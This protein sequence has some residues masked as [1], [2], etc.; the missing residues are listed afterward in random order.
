MVE[1]TLTPG[2]SWRKV[3]I[4]MPTSTACPDCGIE[5]REFGEDVSEM[6]EFGP[7]S[8]KVIRHVPPKLSCRSC[9]K[10]SKLQ[11]PRPWA[12]GG[13][14]YRARFYGY[15]S[16]WTAPNDDCLLN[17]RFA[18]QIKAKVSQSK[19]L[20]GNAEYFTQ[21]EVSRIPSEVIR[22]ASR[23]RA[24]EIFGSRSRR[25]QKHNYEILHVAQKDSFGLGEL[26]ALPRC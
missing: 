4:H 20:H 8:L 6:L 21:S 17:K 10:S 3:H 18:V 9:E 2:A 5:L 19:E 25:P 14:T 13:A 11:R 26:E 16:V 24:S 15:R 1:A 23:K 12:R 7:S 22:C